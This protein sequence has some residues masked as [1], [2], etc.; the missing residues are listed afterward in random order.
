MSRIFKLLALRL[1][2]PAPSRAASHPPCRVHGTGGFRQASFRPA[3][4][5]V[6]ATST[7][8]GGGNV[9]SNEQLGLIASSARRVP[10]VVPSN[11]VA[12]VVPSAENLRR[13]QVAEGHRRAGMR[14]V[15]VATR[16]RPRHRRLRVTVDFDNHRE[17]T[18]GAIVR[19]AG[20]RR[21]PAYRLRRYGQLTRGHLAKGTPRCPRRSRTQARQ[22]PR[23]RH[24]R[25]RSQLHRRE[26]LPKAALRTRL[27]GPR[28]ARVVLR[29]V[30]HAR[31]ARRRAELAW[32]KW[33]RPNAPKGGA[34]YT[35]PA[36]GCF[37]RHRPELG[38]PA[39]LRTRRRRSGADLPQAG[40]T[41]VAP[42]LALMRSS[43]ASATRSTEADPNAG[44]DKNC[45]ERTCCSWCRS[46]RCRGPSQRAR[47]SRCSSRRRSG[48]R[49]DP[50]GSGRG[51]GCRACH[52]PGHEPQSHA[53]TA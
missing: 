14:R 23:H 12:G 24:L 8:L 26:Q 52:R 33:A 39:E 45:S 35:A 16:R 13:N 49:W 36:A 53:G 37:Q 43:V 44:M 18:F 27:A 21:L 51:R 3:M 46:G 31:R 48:H 42:R 34:V 17:G 1:P 4:A 22:H 10:S 2:L 11:G 19:E 41:R 5:R 40:A 29:G 28:L 20:R 7:E 30:T 15:S 32:P 38:R 50:R 9:A 6:T 25:V 47:R